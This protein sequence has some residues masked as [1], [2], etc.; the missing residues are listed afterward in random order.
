MFKEVK[1]SRWLANVV[2]VAKKNGKWRVCVDFT[3]LNKA[4]YIDP[5]PLL[6]INSFVD[7]TT[8]HEILTFMDTSVGFQKIKIVTS[9]NSRPKISFLI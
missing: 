2:V 4:S 9:E 8:S 3:D 6:H 1:F 5:F 7:S